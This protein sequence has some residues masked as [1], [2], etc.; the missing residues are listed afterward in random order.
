VKDEGVGIPEDKLDSI[1]DRFA[2]VNSSLSRRAE[3][4]GLGL[5]LVKKFVEIMGGKIT[6][7]SI[8]DVGSEFKIHFDN[9]PVEST[10]LENHSMINANM[11]DKIHIEFS[12]IN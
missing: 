10:C 1:F 6:V 2:Q 12:D 5:S 7:N 3:G 4:T 11:N 8:L 9:K